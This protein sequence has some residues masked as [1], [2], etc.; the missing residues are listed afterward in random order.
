MVLFCLY[1]LASKGK[2]LSLSSLGVFLIP[3]LV[4]L[5]ACGIPLFLLETSLGQYTNQGSITCWRKICPLFQ[6]KS[7]FLTGPTALY[8]FYF[9]VVF[10]RNEF[11]VSHDVQFQ[12]IVVW[13][14]SMWGRTKGSRLLLMNIHDI[15]LYR[16]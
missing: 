10:S 2:K 8:F 7:I 15:Q 4:F 14:R 16:L 3:Y 9:A 1:N 5:F 11:P 13:Q 6:G 12:A